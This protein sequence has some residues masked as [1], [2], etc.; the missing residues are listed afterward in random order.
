MLS[1]KNQKILEDR[2][3]LFNKD[4]GPRV[5]DFIELPVTDIRQGN[6]TRITYHWTDYVQTGGMSGSYYLSIL[7]FMDYSGGLDPGVKVQ[8][9]SN[10]GKTKNG[11]CWFFDDDLPRA[12]GGVNVQIPCRVFSL[13]SGSPLEGFGELRCPYYLTV[14]DQQAHEKTCGYWFVITRRGMAHTAFKTKEETISWLKQ[15]QLS[16]EK[17]IPEAGKLAGIRIVYPAGSA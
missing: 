2:A 9:L 16:S 7:G 3:A 17:D 11:S 14:L 1:E 6:M 8:F 5:G 12:G 4:P 13:L 15:K 10:T